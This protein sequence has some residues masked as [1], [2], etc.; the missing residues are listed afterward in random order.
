MK[1]KIIR[2]EPDSK[3]AKA[4]ISFVR[5]RD[6]FTRSLKEKAKEI[7]DAKTI[8]TVQA[9]KVQQRLARFLGQFPA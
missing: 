2:I 6:E 5:Q 4:V 8:A 7:A 1:N 9:P 3:Q